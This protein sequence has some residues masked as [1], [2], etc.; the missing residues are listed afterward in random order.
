M[1]TTLARGHRG[2]GQGLAAEPA[3]PPAWPAAGEPSR[4]GRGH[5]YRRTAGPVRY[6]GRGPADATQG[7]RAV[8]A[9]DG[10]GDGAE[11]CRLG[12]DLEG[13]RPEDIGGLIRALPSWT[14]PSW[15]W[16][17]ESRGR[18]GS[19]PRILTPPLGCSTSSYPT[20]RWLLRTSRAASPCGRHAG[21]ARGAGS[22][23]WPRR[24]TRGP[25]GRISCY[26]PTSWSS[27]RRWLPPS[28][29]TSLCWMAGASRSAARA[30]SA[31]R[32]CSPAR[33]EQ[34]SPWPPR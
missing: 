6:V 2:A 33:A 10:A 9:V 4:G 26:P 8:A 24:S 15:S 11:R 7:P 32:R 16:A 12:V 23:G 25:G 14:R 19:G 21:P 3:G 20:W 22:T 1:P 27:C 31:R 30:S 28:G 17:T 29:T 5:G 34:E 18:G 13:A